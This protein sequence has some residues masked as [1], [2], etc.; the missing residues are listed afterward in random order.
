MSWASRSSPAGWGRGVRLL[1]SRLNVSGD[2]ALI[3]VACAGEHAAEEVVAGDEA[4]DKQD[5][6]AD[7]AHAS[8]TEIEAASATP[9]S[10]GGPL[11]RHSCHRASSPSSVPFLIEAVF[12][13]CGLWPY[14]KTWRRTATLYPV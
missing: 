4:D 11:R 12:V 3:V 2:G 13:R 6:E 1:A 5:Y 8:A 10:R 9:E 14:A 7:D